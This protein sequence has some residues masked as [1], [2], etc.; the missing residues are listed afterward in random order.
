MAAILQ[1]TTLT[2][3]L[4]VA[5]QSGWISTMR[6][7]H[8]CQFHINISKFGHGLFGRVCPAD[9]T[10]DSGTHVECTRDSKSTEEL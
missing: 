7:L 8:T 5:G 3:A 10:L 1:R 4:A 6:V 9:L 2:A